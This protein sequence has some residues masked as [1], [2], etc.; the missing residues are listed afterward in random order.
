MIT[1]IEEWP[2]ISPASAIPLPSWPVFRICDLAIWP[3]MIGRRVEPFG[4]ANLHVGIGASHG[5]RHSTDHHDE[6]DGYPVMAVLHQV[7]GAEELGNGTAACC[8]IDTKCVMAAASPRAATKK[9]GHSGFVVAPSVVRDVI[10]GPPLPR[11]AAQH[12]ANARSARWHEIGTKGGRAAA[13]APTAR[14]TM[15][16]RSGISGPGVGDVWL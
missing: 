9:N 12:G 15:S 7:S 2:G 11:K 3:R 6:L 8:A 4:G 16:P 5:D 1:A 10:D 13:F 14:R